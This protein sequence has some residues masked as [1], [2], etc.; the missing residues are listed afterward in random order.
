MSRLLRKFIKEILEKNKPKDGAGIVVVKQF[1]NNEWKV[2]GLLAL[3]NEYDIHKGVIE[4]NETKL[5][6]A[7]RETYEEAGINDL[8]FKWGEQSITAQGTKG[9]V[10]AFIASTTQEPKIAKN[11]ET[12][13]FEHQSFEWM[14]FN[15]LENKVYNYLKPI[16]VWAEQTCKANNV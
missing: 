10:T 8:D 15:N 5:E 7:K 4:K 14:T 13:I 16:I 11:P 6:C 12:N 2:L 1:P 9:K 3:D